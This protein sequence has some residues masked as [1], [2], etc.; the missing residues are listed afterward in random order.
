MIFSDFGTGVPEML[1]TKKIDEKQEKKRFL[2]YHVLG[3]R[4]EGCVGFSPFHGINYSITYAFC[5]YIYVCVH[6]HVRDQVNRGRKYIRLLPIFVRSQKTRIITENARYLN[7][8]WQCVF[9]L[10][11]RAAATLS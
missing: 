7:M 10:R 11:F 3:K 4:R 1:A 6:T 5:A 8:M 9:V 2:S